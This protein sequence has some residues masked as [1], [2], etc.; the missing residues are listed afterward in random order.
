MSSTTQE[1]HGVRT[2]ELVS[3]DDLFS[4]AGKKIVLTGGANGIGA[5]LADGLLARGARLEVWDIA[6]AIPTAPVADDAFVW[7][8][9]DVSSSDA[10]DTAAGCAERDG[11][12]DVL[13]NCGGITAQR[14]PA[15]ETPLEDWQRMIDVNLFG[16][17][18]TALAVGRAMVARRRGSII[19]FASVNAVDPSAGIAHYCVSKAAVAAMTQNLALEWAASGVRVNGIGPGPIVT[20][21]TQALLDGNQALRAKW[22]A[23]VPMGRLGQ[24]SDLLGMVIYLASAAS[25]WATGQTYFVDGGWLL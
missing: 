2:G 9:V 16:S 19:N 15:L 18:H 21:T 5:V 14:R 13:I 7:R 17:L 23:G 25:A 20:E 6:E 11:P 24:P 4:V 8:Q 22:E 12:V 1:S 10:V 3:P